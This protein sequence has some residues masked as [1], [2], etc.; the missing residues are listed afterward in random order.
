[1]KLKELLKSFSYGDVEDIEIDKITYNSEEVFLYAKEK[2]SKRNIS[3][4]Q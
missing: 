1:M 2:L 4:A 3:G